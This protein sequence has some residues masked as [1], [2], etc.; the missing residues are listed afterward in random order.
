MRLEDYPETNDMFELKAAIIDLI[1][2]WQP[3]TADAACALGEL[4]AG[5]LYDF[6]DDVDRELEAV[7]DEFMLIR[8]EAPEDVWYYVPDAHEEA[9][10]ARLQL[11]LAAPTPA[12]IGFGLLL[13]APE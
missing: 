3:S 13:P 7:R 10:P 8:A 9:V 5:V 11:A 2:R 4:L 6:P 12:E 1:E